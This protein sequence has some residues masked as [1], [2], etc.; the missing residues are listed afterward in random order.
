MPRARA[1]QQSKATTV[2]S[3]CTAMKRSPRLPQLEKALAQNED[4]AQVP[5][6]QDPVVVGC[7]SPPS[8]GLPVPHRGP[9]KLMHVK[10]RVAPG[11]PSTFTRGVP[12]PGVPAGHSLS[13][14]TKHIHRLCARLLRC[15]HPT[16]A[17]HPASWGPGRGG[18]PGCPSHPGGRA[19]RKCSL[20]YLRETLPFL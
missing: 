6:D 2:R 9:P 13:S 8:P 20:H 1:P 15:Q 5:T 3:L 11:H 7:R 19:R 18:G 17:T 12:R 10:S 4:P 16:Q 14:C